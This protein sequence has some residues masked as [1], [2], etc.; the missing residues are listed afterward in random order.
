M[1]RKGDLQTSAKARVGKAAAMLVENGMRIG[2]GTGATT[3]FAIQ[4][5]GRRIQEEGLQE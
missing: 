5:V 2:L 3:A 4:E 1:E